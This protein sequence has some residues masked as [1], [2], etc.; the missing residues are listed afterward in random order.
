MI[1]PTV[2]AI[3]AVVIEVNTK[4]ESDDYK[5][6]IVRFL[7]CLLHLPIIQL[8]QTVVFG[9]RLWKVAKEKEKV[10]NFASRMNK[11]IKGCGKLLLIDEDFTLFTIVPNIVIVQNA[12]I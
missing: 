8:F 6:N 5:R 7:K 10:D 11:W 12:I 1:V 4:K 3:V 9:W 2:L